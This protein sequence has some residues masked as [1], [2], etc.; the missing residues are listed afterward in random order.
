M[1][2]GLTN[3]IDMAKR[4][5]KYIYV[6]VDLKKRSVLTKEQMIDLNVKHES[7]LKVVN[8]PAFP[9]GVKPQLSRF[10]DAMSKQKIFR[11]RRR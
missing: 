5:F 3:G 11:L 1:G 9:K 2:H 10:W 4:R 6:P 7:E 8:F